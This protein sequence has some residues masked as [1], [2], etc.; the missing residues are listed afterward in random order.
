M[1]RPRIHANG[2]ARVAAWRAAN[3]DRA[4]SQTRD[5]MRL[6]R[7]RNPGF[8]LTA[9]DLFDMTVAQHGACAICGRV[10]G[11]HSRR[12]AIDHDH[13][14]GVVRGLLCYRC[15]TAIGLLGDDV[16]TV[17]AA[18]AYLHSRRV[19]SSRTPSRPSRCTSAATTCGGRR[20]T[21]CRTPTT[22]SR[23]STAA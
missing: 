19:A 5:H 17:I 6:W 21:C 10:P 4:L 14:T 2:A 23:A 20:P 22:A 15:N 8:G 3:P 12:L 1:G 16:D 13:A 9:D 7:A 11:P 18:A